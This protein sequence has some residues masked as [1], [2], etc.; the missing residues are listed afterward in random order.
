MGSCE[1]VQAGSSTP[2]RVSD[3]PADK[4]ALLRPALITWAATMC[5][6]SSF[7]LVAG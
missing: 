5:S 1:P 6:A 7:L 2:L 4:D 3:L